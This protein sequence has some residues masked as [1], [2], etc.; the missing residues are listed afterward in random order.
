VCLRSAQPRRA[1]H[2]SGSYRAGGNSDERSRPTIRIRRRGSA[3]AT[4]SSRAETP[5]TDAPHPSIKL[6]KAATWLVVS[7]QSSTMSHLGWIGRHPVGGFGGIGAEQAVRLR[8]AALRSVSAIS[9]TFFGLR[10]FVGACHQ[11]GAPWYWR[12]WRRYDEGRGRGIV[13]SKRRSRCQV[14][15]LTGS[16]RVVLLAASRPERQ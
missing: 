14:R 15:G 6:P 8:I 5:T 7:T 1:S 3:S 16:M 4:S 2:G 13:G 11:H 12:T 9:R 10:P